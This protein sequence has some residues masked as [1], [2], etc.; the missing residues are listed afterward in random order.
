[1]ADDIIQLISS[2]ADAAV[3]QIIEDSVRLHKVVNGTG[4]E[5]VV[6]EDGSIIP[7]VRKALVDNLYF[8]TPPIPWRSGAQARE[9]N[10]LYSFEDVNG[11]VSWWYA[12][13]ATNS[14][15]VTQG[16]Q[17]A[18]DTRWRVFL[19]AGNM[20][21]IYAPILSPD[22]RGNPRVPTPGEGD[23]ST[24]IANTLWTKNAIAKAIDIALP[25]WDDAIFNN[26][27]VKNNS[28][29]NNVRADGQVTFTGPKVDAVDAEFNLKKINLVG[30][31]AEIN[32]LWSDGSGYRTNLTPNK[33]FTAEMTANRI[34]GSNIEAGQPRDVGTTIRGHGQ[35]V[36]D[37]V[38]ISKNDRQPVD[39]DTLTVT[40][41]TRVQNLIVEGEAVGI[42]SN[43]D[44]TDISPSNINNQGHI[45][46]KSLLVT[47][48]TQLDGITRI[49]DV[50]FLGSV[51][52]LDM[53]IEFDE[54]NLDNLT[55]HESLVVEGRTVMSA[56]TIGD[57]V[58]TGTVAGLTFPA[59]NIDGM[60]VKPS[61]VETGTLVVEGD[62]T[63][64]NLNV[65]GTV[66]GINLS[67]DG[68]D[69]A[70]SNVTTGDLTVNGQLTMNGQL[71]I[72]NIDG[73][74]V[75]TGSLTVTQG[76]TIQNLSV[77]E[78]GEITG[79]GRVVDGE[80]IRPNS[81]AIT[82]GLSVTGG[83]TVGGGLTVN[84]VTNL[85]DVNITGTV[86]GINPD[87]GTDSTVNTGTVNATTVTANRVNAGSVNTGDITVS[88][89]I[90]D[91]DGN[92]FA[93]RVSPEQ[94]GE[95]ITQIAIQPHSV[96]TRLSDTD[97]GSVTTGRLVADT[98][99]ISTLTAGDLTIQNG[100][101]NGNLT[102]VG[103]LVDAEGNPIASL[104]I[105][106][107]IQGKDISPRNVTAAQL[108]VSGE[109]TIGGPVETGALTVTGGLST[110][111]SATVGE[112][113][114][115]LGSATV[116]GSLNSGALT[117]SSANISG[118][119][120]LGNVVIS[121]TLTDAEGNPLGSVES[122]NGR[123]ITPRNVTASGSFSAVSGGITENLT[124]GG[125]L[126]ATGNLRA[127]E[128][129]LGSTTTASL[130]TGA[131]T[132]STLTVE[133]GSI[134]AP[135]ASASFGMNAT[136]GQDLTVT[137]NTVLGHVDVEFEGDRLRVVGNQ[138]IEGNLWVTG[139]INGN[140]DISGQ[141]INPR[142]VS[143]S[144]DV[145]VAGT[146]TTPIG[147][148]DSLRVGVSGTAVGL[149]VLNNATVAGDLTVAGNINA[150]ID[151][152]EQDVVTKS[153]QTG[154]IVAEA[155]TTNTLSVTG[156]ITATNS[157]IWTGSVVANQFMVRPQIRTL[158]S[159]AFVPDGTTNIYNITLTQNT[160]IEAPSQMI[161]MGLGGSIV[162]YLNQDVTG[163][164]QVTFSTEYQALNDGEINLNP[165]GVTVV[166]LMYPGHGSTIDTLILPR[167]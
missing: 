116:T 4:V 5:T 95:A 107:L 17:P 74:S 59:P 138:R 103:E 167:T 118:T 135:M 131:A 164:R 132:V 158:D 114:S 128:T 142:S 80:D 43:V 24:T 145:N 111:G 84:G 98:G 113:L 23:A 93:L 28:V 165:G 26:I 70:P 99:N 7:T 117:A 10:Q 141:D 38:H 78:D 6:T 83:A 72:N 9:F 162:M 112:Q 54:M 58:F 126:T 109:T 57:V 88:G 151:Q 56:A 159:G 134:S 3:D 19:D 166:Q 18:T 44:G 15:P 150:T 67:V 148:I 8:K 1:M 12:P 147:N 60:E 2:E 30:E 104:D 52:G 31:D 108:S 63:V 157:E 156:N 13:G 152:S 75:R 129:T 115:V 27:T 35:S 48:E 89:R 36:F 22:F 86:T 14:S 130:E 110:T 68:T 120:N 140:V 37:T 62:T 102:L 139:N 101:I 77:P 20:D 61:S 79:F 163:G 55:V 100:R 154:N 82:E 137:G 87:F 11:K 124:V 149:S 69:I 46:T 90:L 34:A 25:S 51:K 119:S 105:P 153:L 125:N 91:E 16:D 121:G 133:G 76:A 144:G 96:T 50:E 45:N 97:K 39:A 40:G 106:S 41:V 73:Q 47:E 42:K 49:G 127:G 21:G 65:T 161:Q 29:L 64:S 81:V 123:D 143:A 53:N 92:D 136:V 94:I 122:I 160:R 146:L 32:F 33:I 66:T 85:R 155:I 71:Q